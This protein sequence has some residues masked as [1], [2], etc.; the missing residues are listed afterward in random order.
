[1][2]RFGF[3]P[4]AKRDATETNSVQAY[5]VKLNKVTLMNLKGKNIQFQY[6]II[7]KRIISDNN[8]IRISNHI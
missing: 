2:S 6:L 3:K 8:N 7:K 1:M 4:L 5:A